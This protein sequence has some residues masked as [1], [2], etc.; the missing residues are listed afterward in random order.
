MGA[1]VRGDRDALLSDRA[2]QEAYQRMFEQFSQIFSTENVIVPETEDQDPPA[3]A[4]SEPTP[5]AAK[6]EVETQ[7]AA[8]NN[9]SL[10]V[11][12]SK[13]QSVP[14]VMPFSPVNQIHV[15]IATAKATGPPDTS[16]LCAC[17]CSREVMSILTHHPQLNGKR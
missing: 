11:V 13:S 3:P 1:Y 5:T 16:I 8:A 17:V 2:L 10:A 6:P 14:K 15:P 12:T 9:S 7:V 4:V